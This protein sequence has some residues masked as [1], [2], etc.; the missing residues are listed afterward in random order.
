MASRMPQSFHSHDGTRPRLDP[1]DLDP[2]HQVSDLIETLRLKL[3]A[4]QV[5]DAEEM[6]AS[7]TQDADVARYM[8]GTRIRLLMKPVTSPPPASRSGPPA[9]H[10]PTP[11]PWRLAGSS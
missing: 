3:R 7:Y 11:S 8:F 1:S 4:P 9:Q 6:F 10:A 2:M 5:S